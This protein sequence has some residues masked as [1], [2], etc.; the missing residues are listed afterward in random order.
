MEQ[1]GYKEIWKVSYPILISLV[2][3]QLI[4]MTDTVFLGRVGELELGASAV[5]GV[6]YMVCICWASDSASGRRL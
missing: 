6:Y 3:E 1:Y 2:M 4:G 5:A